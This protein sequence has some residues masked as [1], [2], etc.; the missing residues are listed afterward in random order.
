[1]GWGTG[2]AFTGVG[3]I[4]RRRDSRSDQMD[5]GGW[6]GLIPSHFVPGPLGR[7]GW[8]REAAQSGDRQTELW[9]APSSLT[10]RGI[11]GRAGSV[12]PHSRRLP[13]RPGPSI[14]MP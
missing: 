5:S 2:S 13:P 11:V 14:S 12:T 8:N 9:S 3:G 10:L 1:M 6:E 7:G 4:E